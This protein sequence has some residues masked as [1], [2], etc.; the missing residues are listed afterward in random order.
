L[1][2]AEKA[3]AGEIEL[4]IVAPSDS[5]MFFHT[6]MQEATLTYDGKIVMTVVDQA[7]TVDRV[8]NFKGAYCISLYEYFNMHNDDQ[9]HTKLTIAATEIS[10]GGEGSSATVF[11]KND[12]AVNE[13][14]DSK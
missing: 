9:M 11:F 4:T 2:P 6:W 14:A 13:S 1:L 7:I 12:K 10:F 3:R 5:D 8:L